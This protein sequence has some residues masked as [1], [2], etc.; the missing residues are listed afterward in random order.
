MKRRDFFKLSAGLGVGMLLPWRELA[1]T[2]LVSPAATLSPAL[3]RAR[4]LQQGTPLPG[5]AIPQF[6]DPLPLLNVPQVVD[7]PI[8]TIIA[9][10]EEIT[11]TMR[12]FQANVMPSAF[13]PAN[14]RPYTG[15][16]VWGYRAGLLPYD[17][18]GTYI[19]PVLVTTR[20]QPTQIRF[21][22]N[23]TADNIAWRDWTDQ[24]LHWAD[25]LNQLPGYPTYVGGKN[26]CMMDTIAGEPP[27]GYCAEHYGGSI[28]AVPHLDGGEQPPVIDGGPEQWF[29][30]DGAHV[31]NAY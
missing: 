2:A 1:R 29:T 6:I 5:S 23:L 9:G 19:G 16:W 13:V 26:E 15:T 28:P 27:M 31:G 11:L 10:T 24:T 22:N 4:L 8:E 20:H 30:A 18:A 3:F 7:G 25:P 17:P 21:V 12:E 14:G